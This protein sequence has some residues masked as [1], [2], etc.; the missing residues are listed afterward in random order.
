MIAIITGDI[1]NSTEKAS[2]SWLKELKSDLNQYGSSPEKWEIYRGDSFQ[3]KLP[4]EKAILAAFHIK[5]T[6]KQIKK[7]DVRMGIGIGKEDYVSK[8]NIRIER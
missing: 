7:K 1:I 3:L 2:S 5:A 6:S 4:V 8:K